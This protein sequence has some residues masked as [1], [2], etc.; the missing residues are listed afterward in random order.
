MGRGGA[1]QDHRGQGGH[2][3]VSLCPS[4][5][6][7]SPSRCLPSHQAPSHLCQEGNFPK[8]NIARVLVGGQGDGAT[9]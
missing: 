9:E 4:K 5:H 8:C 1:G 3:R 7:L 6:L 2:L